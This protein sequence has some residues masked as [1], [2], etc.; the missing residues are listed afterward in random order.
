MEFRTSIKWKGTDQLFTHHHKFW[1]I[2]SCF[3]QHLGYKLATS[4]FNT[5]SSPFGIVFNPLSMQ[6]QFDRLIRQTFYTK[7]ELIFHEGIYHS[8]D[9]H[10]VYSHPDADSLIQQINQILENAFQQLKIADVLVI[11]LGSAHYYQYRSSNQVVAN[12]HKIPQNNFEKKL[13]GVE[14]IKSSLESI[15]KY[16]QTVNPKIPI[17][18][19]VSPV[20]YL[21]DG[22]VEN[23][24]SKSNLIVAVHDIL[25]KY[26][27]THYF[28]AYEIVMDDLRDYRFMKEDLMHPNDQAIQYVWEQFEQNFMDET[29]RQLT[30][31]VL[32]LKSRISHKAL[33]PDRIQHQEFEKKTTSLKNQLLKDHPYLKL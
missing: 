17:I 20:R 18:F 12:C 29:T 26:S 21:K 23:T 24:R 10:G 11:T 28:P 30:K 9:H 22:F 2:G 3:A 31:K 32:E 16:I 5:S 7:D 15:L 4:G 6:L 14:E 19:T 33:H 25:A 13:A 27:Y 1:C 8:F